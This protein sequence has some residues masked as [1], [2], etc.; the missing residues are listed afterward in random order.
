MTGESSEIQSHDE[1]ADLLRLR[2]AQELLEMME[3]EGLFERA[4]RLN[5]DG[6]L[7]TVWMLTDKDKEPLGQ[8]EAQ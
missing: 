3:A 5:Q 2:Q 7:E 4:E 8:L 6:V 1:E